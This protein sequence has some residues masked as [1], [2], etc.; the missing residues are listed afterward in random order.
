MQERLEKNQ[1]RITLWLTNPHVPP[2]DW[3][4]AA[5]SANGNMQ[6]HGWYEVDAWVK[7][8]TPPRL[9]D[10]VPATVA[11]LREEQEKIRGEA[12]AKA[13]QIEAAIEKMLAI[14]YEVPA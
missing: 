2:K 3:Y 8:I 14:G 6:A 11:R 10:V 7:E 4:Y 12:Q 1:L 5:D 9:Q 13:N